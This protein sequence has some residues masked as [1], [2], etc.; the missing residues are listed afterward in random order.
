MGCREGDIRWRVETHC[1]STW[2]PDSRTSLATILRLCR[3]RDITRIAITDHNTAEGALALKRLAPELVI[4][5]EEVMTT[6]GEL[7]AW[8]LQESVPPGLTPAETIRRL[9]D[10]GAIIS[11]SHPFDRF[12]HG[13]WRQEQLEGIVEQV[14][15]IE[16]FN[17]RCLRME[18]NRR[19]QAFARAHGLP[20]SVGSDAHSAPEYGRALQLMR[21]FAHDPQDFL[22]AL[23]TAGQLR[24][25][26]SPLVHFNSMAARW[27]KRLGRQRKG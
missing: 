7:L 2:S 3:E 26:S 22:D 13:A 23:R 8:Y 6:Q 9:R 14:D 27:V 5:G 18:D 19:A 12:R 15:A 24:R 4:V 25:A 17:A 20:G 11:V 1:H 21:P 16:V 10:Q